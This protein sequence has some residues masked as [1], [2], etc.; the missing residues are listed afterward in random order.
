MKKIKKTYI[1]YCRPY[2]NKDDEPPIE[3]M[4]SD[5]EKPKKKL[6]DF[7]TVFVYDEDGNKLVNERIWDGIE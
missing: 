2:K 5:G 7:L 3:E 4:W 1:K 6:A